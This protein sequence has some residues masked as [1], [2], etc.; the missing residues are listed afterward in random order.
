VKNPAV[1]FLLERTMER[2]RVTLSQ[3]EFAALLRLCEAELRN[4][5]DQLRQLLRETLQR[6]NALPAISG[7]G[8]ES[9]H[10]A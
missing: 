7:S 9:K 10:D 2:T 3:E 6:R 8:E 1:L 5:S 4:P